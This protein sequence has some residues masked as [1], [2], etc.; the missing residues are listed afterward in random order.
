MTQAVRTTCPYCGVG[1]GVIAERVAGSEITVRGDPDHPSNRGR[2][3]S[4][5]TALAATLGEQGRLLQP[6]IGGEA[7]S[8]D[9]ALT[10]VADAFRRSIAEHGRESVALY[11]SGQL[12]TEDYYVANKLM[13]GFIGSANI[14]T[15]SRLCMSSAVAG[16][17]RAFGEDVVPVDYEDIDQADLLVLVGSNTAWCHPVL[18][19]RILAAKA[20]RPTLKIVVIDPR[21]TATCQDADL[22]LPLRSGTD[23]A[24][25]NGLL[26]W[27]ASQGC[28]DSQ[29]VAE[30]VSGMEVALAAAHTSSSDIA[31]TGQAC[32]LA[33]ERVEEFFALF[34]QSQ[35]VVTL[36][37]QGVNQSSAGTDKVNSIINCH[38]LTGRIGK[39]GMGPFSITGQ[40]NAMGGREVGGLSNQL[41]A[42]LQLENS[43]HG[44]AVKAYWKAPIIASKPGL[45]AVDLFEAVDAGHI[46]VLWI[47]GTNPV[48]SMPDA[49]RVRR[50]LQ[51]CPT[52]I[53]SDCV[54]N[55]DT[56]RLAH[57][58]LP[59]AA[60]GEKSGTVTNSDRYVSRQ[61]AF[62][63]MPGEARPDWWIISEV[64]KRLGHAAEFGY[65][66]PAEVFAEHAGLTAI[67]QQFG[68]A[69]DLTG[70]ATVNGIDYEA[71]LPQQWPHPGDG[72][73]IQRPFATGR[74]STPDGRARM[75]PTTARAPMHAATSE[76]PLVLNTGRIRDQWHTMTRTGRAAV[77]QAHEW[78]PYIDLAPADLQACELI[79]GQIV[80][81]V[82]RWGSALARVRSSG[83]MRDGMVFMPMHWSEQFARHSRVGAVV[84]PVVD[85]I[86]GEPEFKHTPVRVEHWQAQWQ[87]FLL[88]VDELS[89]V[90]IPWWAKS[91][92]SQGWRY[93]LAGDATCLPD[94]QWLRAHSCAATQW[95]ELEDSVAGSYR[96][97][98]L[99][100]GVLQAVLIVERERAL[101][102]RHW[103]ATQ[104]GKPALSNVERRALL[105]GQAIDG[106]VDPGATVC[107]C[108]GVGTT[109][110]GQAMRAGCSSVA[111]I[112]DHS[113]AGTNCGSCRPELARLLAAYSQPVPAR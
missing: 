80:K 107:A 64:A 22:H 23:V 3:C 37:S 20:V 67:S 53:V 25:F 97:A 6:E 4:K 75:V 40:P 73:A 42:H 110:I 27:L 112:G 11:V 65:A 58:K 8:W 85:P 94:T 84:N 15:N 106:E 95:I 21:R 28:T 30:H 48:V 41:A 89:T 26:V 82:S 61:R 35:R 19:Q 70:Y 44:A 69:L 7:V 111:A 79:V 12:L 9:A 36:F 103:L 76:Y 108:F 2:L 74:F 24:L 60:W 56:L 91:R 33:L 62:L 47:M 16:H 32:G 78:E 83:D 90:S 86:S 43:A 63:P 13:K 104:L 34:A 39:P 113:R 1:C 102:S 68:Y 88:T 50:A 54:S 71:L 59:A 46:K 57:I 18:M 51:R 87:G 100:A 10:A 55:T 99:V 77:L 105:R 93:E 52:V 31:A 49:D 98:A 92:I 96:A 72:V 101:P 29:F 45:K 17:V 66:S 81:V 5:G 38:L 109:A 14:D